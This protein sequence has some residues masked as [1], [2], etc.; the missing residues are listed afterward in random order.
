MLYS[1]Y[2]VFLV[3]RFWIF[4]KGNSTF[5]PPL[6]SRCSLSPFASLLSFLE[7][8]SPGKQVGAWTTYDKNGNVYKI[9]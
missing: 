3:V 4:Y 2:R 9:P 6:S 8:E 5:S 1:P 7:W